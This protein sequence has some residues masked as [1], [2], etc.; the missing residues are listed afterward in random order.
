MKIV[1]VF[2]FFSKDLEHFFVAKPV[3]QLKISHIYQTQPAIC[4][5]DETK[6]VD[7]HCFAC[8]FMVLHDVSC[9]FM[10]FM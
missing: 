7:V 3:F 4:F 10:A 8:E 6:N 2:A 9:L 5:K 1:F